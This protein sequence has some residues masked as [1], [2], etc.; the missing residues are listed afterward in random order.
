MGQ[1]QDGQ[2][3]VLAAV[4]L[5]RIPG[6]KHVVAEIA[7]AQ[8]H[9]FGIACGARCVYDG[10]YIG[11]IGHFAASITGVALIK[12]LDK[13]KVAYIYYDIQSVICFLADF[14]KLSAG[15]E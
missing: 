8:H 12:G 9:T 14:G 3:H 13:V 4:N 10:G 2:E 5:V 6:F 7:V 1:R 11:C 15:Y